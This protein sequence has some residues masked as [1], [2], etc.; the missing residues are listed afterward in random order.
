MTI[1]EVL[2]A[3]FVLVAFVAI[4]IPIYLRANRRTFEAADISRMRSVYLAWSQYQAD[5][6][7]LPSPNLQILTPRL[8]SALILQ[9]DK[10]PFLTGAPFPIEPLLPD[11]EVTADARVSFAYL[12]NFVR[13]G[14]AKVISWQEYLMDPRGGLISSIWQGRITLTGTPFRAVVQGPILRVNTDGSVTTIPESN[15]DVFGNPS[16]LFFKRR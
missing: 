12:P 15:Q 7:G 4:V 2:I 6:N 9:S 14:Q 13:A 8:E 3:L 16:A 11:L 10:D 1:G 5:F